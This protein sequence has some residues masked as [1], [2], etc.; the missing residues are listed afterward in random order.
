MLSTSTSEDV[1]GAPA[2]GRIDSVASANFGRPRAV[3]RGIAF[4]ATN[5]VSARSVLFRVDSAAAVKV[6]L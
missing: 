6:T 2:G 1:A 5:S 4:A 3:F